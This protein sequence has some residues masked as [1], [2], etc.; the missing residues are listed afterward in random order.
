[1]VCTAAQLGTDAFGDAG[2]PFGNGAR[3]DGRTTGGRNVLFVDEP[4]LQAVAA[5]TGG[6]YHAAGDAPALGQ[7]LRDIPREVVVQTEHLEL[8]GAFAAF[9]AGL[10]IG[11][12]VLAVRW[13]PAA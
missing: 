8:T 5:T 9:A 10:V 1:M 13:N 3:P 4:T 11:A 6:T 7:V 2:T 12:L